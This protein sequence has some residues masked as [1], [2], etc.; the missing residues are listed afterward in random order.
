MLLL[1]LTQAEGIMGCLD[2]D[3]RNNSGRRMKQRLCLSNLRDFSCVGNRDTH[4]VCVSKHTLIV[5]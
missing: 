1:E 4:S 3:R 2:Q 5:E